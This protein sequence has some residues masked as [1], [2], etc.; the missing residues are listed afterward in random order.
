MQGPR[1]AHRPNISSGELAL[2]GSLVVGCH[3]CHPCDNHDVSD[4]LGGFVRMSALPVALQGAVLGVRE[5]FS[6]LALCVFFDSPLNPGQHIVHF[7]MATKTTGQDEVI[8]YGSRHKLPDRF[9][10]LLAQ[11]SNEP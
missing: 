11:S 7:A 5:S 8:W 9:D 1:R 4:Y 10:R 6:D 3:S 2:K